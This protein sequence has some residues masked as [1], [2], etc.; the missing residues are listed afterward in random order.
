MDWLF[1]S[2]S[3]FTTTGSSVLHSTPYG[4]QVDIMYESGYRGL[5]MWRS[6]AHWIGGMGI[7][8]FMLAVLPSVSMA[9]GI[10]L[11]QAESPGPTVDKLVSRMR[12]TARIL[13]LIYAA[14]TLLQIGLL[15]IAIPFD[16][17]MNVFHAVIV[18]FGTAGTGGFAATSGNIG[19]FGPY[20]RA[21]V[22]VFMFLFAVNFNIYYMILLGRLRAALGREELR[23]Y[24]FMVVASIALVTV[25]VWLAAPDYPGMTPASAARWATRLSRWCPA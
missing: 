15:L 19:D 18:S 6:L 5:L 10:H 4:H 8:V 14:M 9:S 13:Y 7:L 12:G 11:M 2:I 3:G 24:F 23:F 16:G 20:V 25:N 1:E 21:V 22:A 17:A